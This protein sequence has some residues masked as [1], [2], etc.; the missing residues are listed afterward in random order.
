LLTRVSITGTIV[1]QIRKDDR[2]FFG[3]DDSTGV[4]T[5]VLWLNDNNSGGGAF[6]N[7]AKRQSDFRSWLTEKNVTIGSVLT[8]LGQ[9]EYYKDKIQVNVHRLREITNDTSEEMLQYQQTLSAQKCFFD[10]LKPFQRRLFKPEQAQIKE[11]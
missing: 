10:P 6:G 4:M 2:F 7:Q 8:V 9:F 1:F 3:I 5:C 11:P